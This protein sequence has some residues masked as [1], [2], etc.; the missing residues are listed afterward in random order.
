MPDTNI[1][2]LDDGPYIVQGPAGIK[3]GE[4]NDL[5]GGETIAL[6]RCGDS[7]NKPF[8]DGTHASAGCSSSVRAD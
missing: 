2:V 5:E 3:D 7:S 1:Q 4:G 6:C 8:C